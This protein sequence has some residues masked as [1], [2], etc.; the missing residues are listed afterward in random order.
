LLVEEKVSVEVPEDPLDNA[1]EDGLRATVGPE[2]ETV[3]VSDMLPDS[4]LTL[5]SVM[6]E[7]AEVPGG[8][9]SELGLATIVKSTTCT[10]TRTE[11]LRE[12]LVPVTVT[13]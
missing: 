1:T 5:E 8:V 7:L 10:T 13:V 6:L 2:G 12:P 4:P 11:W 3:A 9:E